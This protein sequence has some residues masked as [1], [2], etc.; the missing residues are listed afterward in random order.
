MEPGDDIDDESTDEAN[1][2]QDLLVVLRLSNRLMGSAQERMDLEAFAD[3]L[4]AAVLEAGVGEYDG[5]EF[6]GGECVLFF[7]GPDVD[8]LLAV[9]HPLLKRSG[10]CRGGHLVRMVAGPDGEMT[11]QRKPI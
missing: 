1:A 2:E 5:D 11:Q 6:G 9:L 7:C 4:E 3:Q 10:L 8:K